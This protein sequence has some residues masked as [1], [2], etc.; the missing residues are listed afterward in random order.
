MTRQRCSA[1]GSMR[2]REEAGESLEGVKRWRQEHGYNH[3]RAQLA[4]R[5]H[6][7]GREEGA[8]QRSSHGEAGVLWRPGN[9]L[10]PEVR[11]RGDVHIRRKA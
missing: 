6:Q 1:I 8:G 10:R 7:G 3:H 9:L 2:Q 11:Q 5:N 4:G